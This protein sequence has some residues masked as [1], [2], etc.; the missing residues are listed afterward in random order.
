VGAGVARL[1]GV[2][3]GA[4]PQVTEG[5]LRH[6]LDQAE[7]EGVIEPEERAMLEGAIDFRGKQV[8]EVMTPRIDIVGV[9]EVMPLRAVLDVAMQ[10]GHSRL[11]VYERS[12]DTIV[13]VIATKDLL[14]HLRPR[15]TLG[16]QPQVLV[17]R[18]VMRPAFYLPQSKRIDAAIDD[19]RRQRMLMAIVVE[20][21]GGT[22]GIVTLE[23]LLEEIVGEIEDEY[24]EA[25][26]PLRL[27]LPEQESAESTGESSGAADGMVGQVVGQVAPLG[28]IADASCSVRQAEKFWRRHLGD[29]LVL[30]EH[31]HP[32]APAAPESSTGTSPPP[33]AGVA[34]ESLSLAA[35]AQQLFDGV[36]CEGDRARAGAVSPSGVPRAD[37]TLEAATALVEME[38][39]RA[40]GP[41]LEEVRLVR[42]APTEAS[43]S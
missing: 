37:A 9:P 29:S 31:A 34:P 16:E 22:A 25:E 33:G 12:V 5:D 38:I 41:R 42:A 23:D 17:A 24:D 32:L 30:F 40:I 36:P 7:H 27:L 2:R 35:L 1:F 14:P 26:A 10:Q 4:R 3:S 11:P 39:A 19:L 28:I 20:P 13:G 21:D 6:A 8:R 18:D 43:D 15:E